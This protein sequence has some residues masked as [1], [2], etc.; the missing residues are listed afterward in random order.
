MPSW[1]QV[2]EEIQASKRTDAFD[3]TRRKYLHQLHDS[4]GRNIIAYYSGWLQKPGIGNASIQDDD[5]NGFMSTIH[6]LDRSKG[7]DLILHTPGGDLALIPNLM[8][9]LHMVSSPNFRKPSKK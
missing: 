8:E 1:T 3:Y 5:K 9:S 4:T 7:L 2:L 6:G